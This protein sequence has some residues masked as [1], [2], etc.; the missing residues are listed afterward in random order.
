MP[1]FHRL[2]KTGHQITSSNKKPNIDST[3]L[4][5]C[6]SFQTNLTKAVISF[7]YLLSLSFSVSYIK[8]RQCH[9]NHRQF[10]LIIM[11]HINLPCYV[12]NSVLR[13]SLK[14]HTRQPR[15]LQLGQECGLPQARCLLGR[16]V[17]RHRP[18][19]EL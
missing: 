9:P 5:C 11:L 17:N 1:N 6:L 4:P 8:R 14:M 2:A 7:T 19:T 3:Q 10:S 12:T 16:T 15:S 13:I 18:D